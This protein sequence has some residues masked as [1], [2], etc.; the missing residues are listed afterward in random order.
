MDLSST[1]S[2]NTEVRHWICRAPHREIPRYATGFVEHLI[3]KYQGTLPHW[4]CPILHREIPKYATV[5]GFCPVPHREYQGTSP[6]LIEKYQGTP[7]TLAVSITSWGSTKVRTYVTRNSSNVAPRH[8]EWHWLCSI[9]HWE[10]PRYVTTLAVSSTSSRNTKVRYCHCPIPLLFLFSFFPNSI[11]AREDISQVDPSTV[12]LSYVF[13]LYGV[14]YTLHKKLR[15]A[16]SQTCQRKSTEL[17]F[18][19][20]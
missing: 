7:Q 1:S 18:L 17:N 15:T 8:G 16:F 6:S 9:P 4:L 5:T 19:K 14:L 2:R 12:T 13:Y 11:F 3:E 20:C 10:I